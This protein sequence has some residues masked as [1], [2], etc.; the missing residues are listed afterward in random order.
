MEFNF[1]VAVNKTSYYNNEYKT[2]NL[3]WEYSTF[4]EA[5]EKYKE[6]VASESAHASTLNSIRTNIIITMA[7]KSNIEYRLS[8]NN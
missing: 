8:V 4:D 6:E 5:Y 2:L 1:S 7:H 3:C